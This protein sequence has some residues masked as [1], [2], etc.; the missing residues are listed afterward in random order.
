VATVASLSTFAVAFSPDRW[1]PRSSGISEIGW[2]KRT[3]IATLLIMGLSTAAVGMVPSA[4]SIG[5]AA[6]LLLLLLRL[7]QGFAVGGEWAGSALLSA[8]YAPPDKRGRYGMFTQLGVGAGLLLGNLVFLLVNVTVGETS[9]S[10]TTWGWRVP[11]LFSAVLLIIAFYIRVNIEETPVFVA[12]QRPDSRQAPLSAWRSD[13]VGRRQLIL[14]G[15][16]LA[17][18]WSFA[19]MPLMNTGSPVLFGVGHRG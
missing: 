7:L 19:V 6:P 11:F 14:T 18:P 15:F 10:F 16:G 17:V 4:D 12:Q 5:M 8:E 1:V 2:G 13:S 9:P 3:L